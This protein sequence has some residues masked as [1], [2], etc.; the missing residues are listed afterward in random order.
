LGAAQGRSLA[1][2]AFA[3]KADTAGPPAAAIAVGGAAEAGGG[4]QQSHIHKRNKG[5]GEAAEL[6]GKCRCSWRKEPVMA[7]HSVQ[8]VAQCQALSCCNSSAVELGNKQEALD[9][10]HAAAA[11]SG[12]KVG[13]ISWR[14]ERCP[15]P[16]PLPDFAQAARVP[17]ALVTL[18]HFRRHWRR[19]IS[20]SNSSD[21]RRSWRPPRRRR[22][23]RRSRWVQEG[24]LG[25]GFG[26]RFQGLGVKGLPC[27]WQRLSLLAAV[28]KAG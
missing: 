15:V 2:Q 22:L 10:A 16:R 13:P 6:T 12:T 21:A 4:K 19:R 25:L 18:A 17:M 11:A 9:A 23:L 3:R 1:R 20:S 5:G 26:F 14:C 7:P 28:L 24:V 27:P 8:V